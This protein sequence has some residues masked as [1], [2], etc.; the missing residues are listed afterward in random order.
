MTTLMQETLIPAHRM[1]PGQTGTI[2]RFSDM[3]VA[4][5]MMAMGILPEAR[6]DLI[7]RNAL[8]YTLIFRVNARFKIALRKDEAET[9]LVNGLS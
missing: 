9:I 7:R 3:V 6:I 5:K 4:G 1:R 8:G 2:V